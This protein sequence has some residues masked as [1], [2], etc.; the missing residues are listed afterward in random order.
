VARTRSNPSQPNDASQEP[1]REGYPT[2]HRE[3]R[4]TRKVGDVQMNGAEEVLMERARIPGDLIQGSGL[5][6]EANREEGLVNGSGSA[7]AQMRPA[8]PQLL[9]RMLS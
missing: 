7:R 8:H 3:A 4:D 5:V 1:Q 9:W 6:N 2:E